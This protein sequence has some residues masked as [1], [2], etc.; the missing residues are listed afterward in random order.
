MQIILKGERWHIIR[1]FGK[2][3]C[4]LFSCLV[5]ANDTLGRCLKGKKKTSAED[6]AH[7]LRN[8]CSVHSGA[9]QG[10]WLA[11]SISIRHAWSRWCRYVQGEPCQQVPAFLRGR[12]LRVMEPRQDAVTQQLRSIPVLSVYQK[13]PWSW[14]RREEKFKPRPRFPKKRPRLEICG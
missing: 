9:P 14:M 5:F 1:S 8:C 6:Q 12:G 11:R 13:T 3:V 7:M 10:T 2:K 4:V